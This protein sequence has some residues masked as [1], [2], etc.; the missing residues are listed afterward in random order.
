MFGSRPSLGIIEINAV[1]GTAVDFQFEALVDA[2]IA[3]QIIIIDPVLLCCVSVR[4]ASLMNINR[5]TVA[6]ISLP[7]FKLYSSDRGY[8]N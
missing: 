6:F 5:D 4:G 3:K 7:H 2:T 1:N 8:S